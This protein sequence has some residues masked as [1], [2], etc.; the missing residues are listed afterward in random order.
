MSLSF[1]LPTCLSLTNPVF[2]PPFFTSCPVLRSLSFLIEVLGFF[3]MRILLRSFKG[4]AFEQRRSLFALHFLERERACLGGP[5][6]TQKKTPLPPKTIGTVYSF[7]SC[8][9][10][11]FIGSSNRIC[12][13]DG[14]VSSQTYRLPLLRKNLLDVWGIQ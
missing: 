5:S 11:F 7:S 10:R 1:F 2:F 3:F 6:S 8:S 12:F 13:L 9:G 4:C 14:L